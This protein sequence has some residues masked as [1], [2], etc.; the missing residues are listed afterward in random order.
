MDFRG[1]DSKQLRVRLDDQK[2]I[3]GLEVEPVPKTGANGGERGI[4][5][6]CGTKKIDDELIERQAVRKRLLG[7]AFANVLAAAMTEFDP[8]LAFEFAVAGADGVG[9]KAKAA[10]D[11]AGAGE[12]LAGSEVAAHDSEDDLCDELFADGDFGAASEP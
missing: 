8:T 10:R 3:G 9:M 2:M 4:A 7:F 5:A 12:A 1:D 11:F 6:A